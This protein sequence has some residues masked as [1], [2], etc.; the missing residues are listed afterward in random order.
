[1]HLYKSTRQWPRSCFQPGFQKENTCFKNVFIPV[2]FGSP[3]HHIWLTRRIRP[4]C[5][6]LSSSRIPPQTLP[7]RV[8]LRARTITGGSLLW[9]LGIVLWGAGMQADGDMLNF[10]LFSFLQENNSRFV[11]LTQFSNMNFQGFLLRISRFLNKALIHFRLNISSFSWFLP[12]RL[13]SCL[14]RSFFEFVIDLIHI[15]LILNTRKEMQTEHVWQTTQQK[16]QPALC[17]HYPIM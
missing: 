16:Q 2:W 14:L 6:C 5:G 9:G 15:L 11:D 13:F 12:Y 1:M 10:P 4:R 17:I 8:F 7:Q 3:S